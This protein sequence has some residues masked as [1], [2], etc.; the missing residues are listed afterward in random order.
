MTSD[1]VTFRLN[2][3]HVDLG[4][5]LKLVGIAM[6]GGEGKQIVAAGKVEVDGVLDLSETAKIRAGR[7]VV[8][9]GVM[10]RVTA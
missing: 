7:T 8:R 1:P 2:S 9:R 6:S 10:V 3:A 5:L 4:D